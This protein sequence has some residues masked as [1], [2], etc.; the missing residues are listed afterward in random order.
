[1]KAYAPGFMAAGGML[2]SLTAAAVCAQ[3]VKPAHAYEF[4]ENLTDSQGGPPLVSAGGVMQGGKYVFAPGKGPGVRGALASPDEYTIELEVR[5]KEVMNYRALINFDNLKP[6][7]R[8]VFIRDGC[9]Q[10]FPLGRQVQ[11]VTVD[12]KE[13]AWCRMVFTRDAVS[14]MVCCYVD[15]T[16]RLS[17][18]DPQGMYIANGTADGILHFCR[19]EG[20]ENSAGELEAVRIYHRALTAAEVA[21]LGK[22]PTAAAPRVPVPARPVRSTPTDAVR[23]LTPVEPSRR[24]FTDPNPSP[25]NGFG[26]IRVTLATGNVVITSPQA[27]IGGVTDCGAVY[28]FNGQTGALIS[29]LTGSTAYDS[30]GSGGVT[31]LVNGHFVV[32]SPRWDHGQ[33][34]DAGAVTWGDGTA[35]IEGK[36]SAEN[37]LTGSSAGD[38][39]GFSGVT[40]LASG[41]YVV[42][43]VAWDY[44]TERDAGAA[45]WGDGTT[46]VRGA[47][48]PENSLTGFQANDL[49]GS[50]GV[51]ALENGDYEVLSPAWDH[52]GRINAGAVTVGD[53]LRGLVGTVSAE[54][55]HVGGR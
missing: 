50:G 26:K 32:S 49:V 22:A 28:L 12:I 43:S 47:V 23:N 46:G 30:A 7:E 42:C 9:I 48:S 41:N 24:E 1:M 18:H 54:T 51:V 19:D 27:D 2:F 53:G 15:G 52:G 35:G 8:S 13:N 37:S 34:P 3:D 55:S 16:L 45:T 17:A 31:A 39:V 21:S 10:F 25:H 40:A 20:T 6:T 33:V 29:T 36:V 11:S 14:A 5:M 4:T 38:R 44:G